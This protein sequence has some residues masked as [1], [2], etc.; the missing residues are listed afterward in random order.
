MKKRKIHGDE[1]AVAESAA[2]REGAERRQ[3]PRRTRPHFFGSFRAWHG[4]R[5][6]SGRRLEDQAVYVDRYERRLALLAIGI[7]IL[8]LVDAGLTLLLMEQGAREVNVFMTLSMMAG[9]GWFLAVKLT[10]TTA[11][12][13]ALIVHQNFSFLQRVAIRDILLALVL[14]YVLLIVYETSLLL[15]S[16]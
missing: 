10:A 14:A 13:L 5:R 15:H 8:S 3:G 11:G 7:V 12:V 9:S 4:G 1:T 6:Q 16:L 2:N